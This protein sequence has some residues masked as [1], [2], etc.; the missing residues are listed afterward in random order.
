MSVQ[1]PGVTPV[2][3]RFLECSIHENGKK[4]RSEARAV[5][6]L[7][8]TLTTVREIPSLSASVYSVY[9]RSILRPTVEAT[10]GEPTNAPASHVNGRRGDPD[11][12]H[13]GGRSID[14]HRPR[15][16][17]LPGPFIGPGMAP[18]EGYLFRC[19]YFG[20]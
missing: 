10:I 8:L 15:P 1:N 20:E 17:R 9:R 11:A 3:R 7:Y 16:Y 14:A 19:V 18:A 2:R 5:Y 13:L 4:P 12:K 6:A